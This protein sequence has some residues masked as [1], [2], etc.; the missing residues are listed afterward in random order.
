MLVWQPAD[1]AGLGGPDDQQMT[2]V[3]NPLQ[4]TSPPFVA[5]GS[6]R[7]SEDQDAA[8]WT[9]PDGDVWKAVAMR[10]LAA[11]GDQQMLGLAFWTKVGRLAAGGF[12]D[13]SG[14]DADAALWISDDASRWDRVPVPATR[15]VNELINR[16]NGTK[17]GLVG[18]GWRTGGSTDGEDGAIW[19]LAAPGA[20]AEP[21]PT[22]TSAVPG[23][24]G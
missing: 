12:E 23:T 16:V 13:V 2:D 11:S 8:V 9:S 10:N 21:S 18:A 6:R 22:P 5:V 19:I 1:T 17:V 24:S 14:G 15:G 20:S 4:G 7:T 3:V